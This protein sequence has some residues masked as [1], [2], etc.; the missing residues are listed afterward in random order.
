MPGTS[1]AYRGTVR[2]AT[3]LLPA[4]AAL[5]AKLARGHFGRQGAVERL[6]SWATRE[7]DPGRPLLWFHAPS[8]GEGLQAEAVLGQIRERHPDWQI[9]YTHFSPSAEALAR[10]V[11]ASVSD[12]LPYDTPEAAHRLLAALTPAAL[13]FS[14]LDM[15]PEL[16]TSAASAGIPVALIAATVR[17]GSGRLRWPVRTL[18]APGYRALTAVAAVDSPDAERL[19]TLGARREVIQVLGDPRSDSVAAKV[20]AVSPDDPLLRFGQG[21]PTLVAGS[22][23]P[24][25]EGVLLGA[26]TRVRAHHPAARLIIVPHE[27]TEPHLATIEALAR[28][29]G[30][31]A[32]TRLNSAPGAVPLLVV[33]RVGVLAALYGAGTLAY[34]GGGFHAA[35]LHSVLEPAAWGVPVIFGPGWRESRD[36]AA[37]LDAGGA[38]A[39]T[40]SG[41][42]EQLTSTWD[43]WLTDD[44]S[45]AHAGQRARAVIDAGRGAANRT[46]ELVAGLV[47]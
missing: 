33:D 10:R 36:A 19:V 17:P 21:A 1:L 29:H 11:G 4:V 37:L 24:G 9:V 32:A 6:R 5:D 39:L 23:W 8:V 15:W 14:K 2:L 41:G 12:Y 20:A 43:K 25:D 18:L 28:R 42:V 35:G 13:V 40:S 46:A 45:R 44:A 34:V 47:R 38:V 22:T 30:L 26:F 27:P 3:A 16:A 31:P 7:R